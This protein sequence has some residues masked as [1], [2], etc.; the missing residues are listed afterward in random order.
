MREVP[1]KNAY[2]VREYVPHP[3]AYP[4]LLGQLLKES[5]QLSFCRGNF[6]LACDNILPE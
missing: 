3:A 1:A 6:D 4:R 2:G 5:V